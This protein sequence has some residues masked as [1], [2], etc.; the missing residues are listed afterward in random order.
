MSGQ[1][2]CILLLLSVVFLSSS[3]AHPFIRQ[4]EDMRQFCV[5]CGYECDKCKYGYTVSTHC[6]FPICNRGPGEA[7]GGP[8]ELWGICGD[9][10]ICSCNK[11]IGCSMLE[12]DCYSH[13]CPPHQ[14]LDTSRHSEAY[15]RFPPGTE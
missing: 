15:F 11:C 2:I 1:S 4:R 9:G 6:G 13:T 5:G 8:S 12:F 3:F 10:L 7:C 14:S